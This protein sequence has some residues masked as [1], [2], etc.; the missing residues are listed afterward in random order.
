MSRRVCVGRRGDNGSMSDDGG[1]PHVRQSPHTRSEETRVA[2]LTMMVRVPDQ[3]AAVRV[4]TD[5]EKN[6]AARYAAEVRGEVVPLPL[7]PPAGYTAGIS[8]SLMEHALTEADR[9]PA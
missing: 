5:D 8:G 9:S 6:E 1:G 4:Y 2:D 7:S 3:P